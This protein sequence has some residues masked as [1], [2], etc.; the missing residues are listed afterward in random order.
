MIDER[1]RTLVDLDSDEDWDD[2]EPCGETGCICHCG[3]GHVCSCDCD[4]C[5]DCQ[6]LTANCDCDEEQEWER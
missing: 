6:Q 5:G 3:E 1:D 4:R 2:R